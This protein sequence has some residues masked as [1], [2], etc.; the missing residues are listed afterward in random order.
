MSYL[1]IEKMKLVI[2]IANIG[3]IEKYEKIAIDKIIDEKIID[4]FDIDIDDTEVSKLSFKEAVILYNAHDIVKSLSGIDVDKILLYW[5]KNRNIEYEVESD[6]DE[7]AYQRDGYVILE[8]EAQ[9]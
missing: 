4:D 5:L 2:E 7:S 3:D 1:I 8:I 6:I 9:R